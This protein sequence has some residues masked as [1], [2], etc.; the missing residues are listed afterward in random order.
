MCCSIMIHLLSYF[1]YDFLFVRPYEKC[2][3]CSILVQLL[4]CLLFLVGSNIRPC[5]IHTLYP[6]D[7][8]FASVTASWPADSELCVQYMCLLRRVRLAATTA[9]G[10]SSGLSLAS[11]SSRGRRAVPEQVVDLAGKWVQDVCYKVVP[12]WVWAK[13]EHLV[14]RKAR[15][16]SGCVPQ[17]SVVLRIAALISSYAGGL[18]AK[19]YGVMTVPPS[20]LCHRASRKVRRCSKARAVPETTKV[21]VTGEIAVLPTVGC[22][23]LVLVVAVTRRVDAAKVG[24]ALDSHPWFALGDGPRSRCCWHAARAHH[25]CRLLFPPD[26]PCERIGS[27]MRL[28]WDQRQGRVPPSSVADRI[29]LAQAGVDCLG[30]VRDE[31][32][33][34]EVV[35]L[36]KN[37]SKYKMTSRAQRKRARAMPFP[38]ASGLSLPEA[39]G[40]SL[41]EVR[42]PSHVQKKNNAFCVSG[43]WP[44]QLPPDEAREVLEPLELAGL[45]AVGSAERERILSTRA[46]QSRPLVLPSSL[47]AAV[48]KATMSGTVTPLALDTATLHAGQHGANW[49]VIR[50]KIVAWM[51]SEPGR[52]WQSDREALF[53]ADDAE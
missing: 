2:M 26:S 40:L 9:S 37:T 6:H 10:R 43:R 18:P 47:C 31:M 53:R 35:E 19:A 50:S 8:A 16:L 24:G 11:Q 21:W 45:S 42:G 15:T 34:E 36:L 52:L 28:F 51:E 17:S 41:P 30:G 7:P 48:D 14:T 22:K 4:S 20:N 38:E 5:F 3:C 44:R 1:P 32:I 46:K 25:R 23:P 29:Y 33:V 49:S 13:V 39:S 12:V 27:L